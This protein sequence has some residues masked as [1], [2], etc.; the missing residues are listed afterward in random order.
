[1]RINGVDGREYL[2]DHPETLSILLKNKLLLNYS[3]ELP[4]CLLTENYNRSLL[5]N[6]NK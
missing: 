4:N 2:N 5:N 6:N 1:M 3:D